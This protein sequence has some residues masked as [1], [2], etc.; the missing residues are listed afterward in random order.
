MSHGVGRRKLSLY[1]LSLDHFTFSRHMRHQR[2]QNRAVET[3]IPGNG[4][5]AVGPR[6]LTL[7]GS[8]VTGLHALPIKS[9][10]ALG[11]HARGADSF[12]KR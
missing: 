3:R 12:G 8:R 4:T 5:R 11:T 1:S 7:L 10:A 2:H 9:S 6:G